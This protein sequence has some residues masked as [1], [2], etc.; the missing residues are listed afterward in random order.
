M[1][2]PNANITFCLFIILLAT[3]LPL[4]HAPTSRHDT[5]AI[6]NFASNPNKYPADG[7]IWSFPQNRIALVPK[8]ATI[9]TATIPGV[10]GTPTWRVRYIEIATILP[11]N[12]VA[13]AMEV[14]LLS[15]LTQLKQT[16]DSTLSEML[17]LRKGEFR[18]RRG[19][20]HL[21]FMTKSG[22]LNR[23]FIEGV[24]EE[25]LESTRL[26]WVTQFKSEWMDTV[27]GFT[28]WV[29]CTLGKEFGMTGLIPGPID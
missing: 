4:C 9:H 13:I 27:G 8:R 7:A 17:A 12:L 18:V 3:L 11:I 14:L 26:G 6:T 23:E 16:S 15:E 29:T 22:Q 5:S 19:I 20:F 25:L 10:P 1:Y 21:N 2:N 28:V 24:M